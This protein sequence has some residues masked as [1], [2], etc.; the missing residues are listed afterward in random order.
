MKEPA[1]ADSA[2]LIAL[3]QV[4][5]LALLPAL[6]DPVVIPPE[7]EREFGVSIPWL[8][9]EVPTNAASV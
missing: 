7:V 9:V 1:V 2:C 3:E 6:F 4:N 8:K 5:Q